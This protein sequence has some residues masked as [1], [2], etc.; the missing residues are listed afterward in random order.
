MH[1]SLA[2]YHQHHQELLR[3]ARLCETGLAAGLVRDHPELCL[4]GVQRLVASTKA[5]LAMENAVLYPA[6]LS[7]PDAG[8]QATV[9]ALEADLTDLASPLRR[10][11]HYWASTE[12]ISRAPEAFVSASLN[13]LQLLRQRIEEEVTRLFPLVERA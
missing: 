8:F 3:L 2:P 5:H 13:L 11:G 12:A 1:A 6:L 4:A 9:R 10:F 7:G